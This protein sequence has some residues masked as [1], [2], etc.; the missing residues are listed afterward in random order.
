MRDESA[1]RD[2]RSLSARG[3]APQRPLV[4]WTS[5]ACAA[6]A[7]AAATLGWLTGGVAV[8]VPWA[9]TLGL[10][11]DLALDGLGALY[12]LLATGIGVAVFTYGTA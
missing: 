10:R 7:F 4:A 3:Q 8:D 12:A 1:R 2:Q 9:P 5:V 6:C 11:L